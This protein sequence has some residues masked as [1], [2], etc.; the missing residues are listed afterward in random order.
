MEYDTL[1]KFKSWKTKYH[2]LSLTDNQLHFTSPYY[3]NDPF[4]FK[5]PPNFLMLD[6]DEKLYE[7]ID[8]C[9]DGLTE[10]FILQMGGWA[11]LREY[12]LREFKA[13]LHKMQINYESKY[14]PV[15]DK[16]FGL[17]CFSQVWDSI[18][19]WSHYAC[20]HFGFC[21]GFH[22]KKFLD[23]Y[24]EGSLGLVQYQDFP[25]VDPVKMKDPVSYIMQSH[26]KHPGWGYE[27]EFRLV[28]VE[29][30]E[31]LTDDQRK[32]TYPDH[33]LK[34]ITLGLRIEDDDK[35]AIIQEGLKKNVPFYQV[36][37]V[38]LSFQLSRRLLT[39]EELETYQ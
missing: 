32:F 36:E 35:A 30:P 38:P 16:N 33:F 3:M 1:Y 26:I 13:D 34:D 14:F 29:A 24:R 27:E 7:Y 22:K 23:E 15:T 8:A 4:D 17:L 2:P 6:T 19:M 28:K 18:L 37:K 5:I 9:M 10:E 11:H 20:N 25:N 31:P 12:K 21:L 39:A